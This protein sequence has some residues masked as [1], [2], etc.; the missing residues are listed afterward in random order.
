[1]RPAIVGIPWK[2]KPRLFYALLADH[3]AGLLVLHR[4]ALS[5]GIGGRKRWLDWER[6]PVLL[7]IAITEAVRRRLA[8]PVQ[9]PWQSAPS[10]PKA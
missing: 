6:L 8:R 1:M 10:A 4:I 3:G 7:V 9:H 2:G 5:R